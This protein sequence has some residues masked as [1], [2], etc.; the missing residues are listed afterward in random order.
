MQPFFCLLCT[1]SWRAEMLNFGQRPHIFHIFQHFCLKTCSSDAKK[2]SKEQ[3]YTSICNVRM[4]SNN[5]TGNSSN[6]NSENKRKCLQWNGS[7]RSSYFCWCRLAFE[8]LADL[9]SGQKSWQWCLLSQSGCIGR[10]HKTLAI[11][12]LSPQN[13]ALPVSF[14]LRASEGQVGVTSAVFWHVA[15]SVFVSLSRKVEVDRTCR[16]YV[17]IFQEPWAFPCCQVEACKPLLSWALKSGATWKSLKRDSKDDLIASCVRVGMSLIGVQRIFGRNNGDQPVTKRSHALS[18]TRHDSATSTF[19]AV[20]SLFAMRTSP[21]LQCA[22]SELVNLRKLWKTT[23]SL[24]S[25]D[26]LPLV[27]QCL[28]L[29]A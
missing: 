5:N 27:L 3:L 25:S 6:I 14:L 9:H 20:V 21:S 1:C 28:Q 24:D 2:R 23:F 18:L 29:I 13:A 26:W 16:T 4:T 8:L 12:S 11:L 15:L 22:A 19:A 10:F 17:G 7:I